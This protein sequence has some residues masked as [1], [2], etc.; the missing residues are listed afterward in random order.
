MLYPFK[1]RWPLSET[2]PEAFQLA[3]MDEP[4]GAA[5]DEVGWATATFERV[6]VAGVFA[7]EVGILTEEAELDAEI[8]VELV[9]ELKT[10]DMEGAPTA[11]EVNEDEGL[12]LVKDGTTLE[13]AT[14]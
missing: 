2:Q 7:E 5:A 3:G 8:G 9:A 4:E 14:E 10:V 6:V 13:V 12:E 1:V 11:V